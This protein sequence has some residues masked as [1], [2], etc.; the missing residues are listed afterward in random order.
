MIRFKHPHGFYKEAPTGFSWTT[1]FFGFFVPLFRGWYGYAAICFAAAV[2][3][4]GF[5][6]LV[7]PFLI[8]KH[9]AKHLLEQGYQPD[10]EQDKLQLQMMGILFSQPTPAHHSLNKEVA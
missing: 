1:F 8:N 4:F 7:F 10:S 3:T 5:S 2:V 6:G 9:Y